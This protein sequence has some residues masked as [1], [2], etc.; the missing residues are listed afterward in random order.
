MY[1]NLNTANKPGI[2]TGAHMYTVVYI[3][4]QAYINFAHTNMFISC[5][6]PEHMDLYG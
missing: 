3:I 2:N 4:T 1:V 5:S 6:N